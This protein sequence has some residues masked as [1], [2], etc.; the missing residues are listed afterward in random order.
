MRNARSNLNESF[1]YR[2]FQNIQNAKGDYE[3]PKEKNFKQQFPNLGDNLVR[4]EL[5]KGSIPSAPLHFF[6]LFPLEPLGEPWVSLL[7][8]V[9][10]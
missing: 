1:D 2:T 3:F 8:G 5:R 4:A 10:L 6:S 9:F 7:G